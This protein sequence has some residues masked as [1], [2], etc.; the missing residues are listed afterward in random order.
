MLTNSGVTISYTTAVDATYYARFEKKFTLN[1][2]KIDG[3][4]STSENKVPL[5]GAEFTLYQG[6]D[7]GDKTV[8]YQGKS[9]K[10]TEIDSCI[11]VL[12]EDGKTATA[13][14]DGMLIPNTDYFLIE[15]RAPAGYRLLSEAKKITI[16][17]SGNNA[18]IDGTSKEITEKKVNVEL[19]NYLTLHI[20]TSGLNITGG[21][22][23]AV[24]L[25][26]LAAAAIGLFGFKISRIRSKN[27]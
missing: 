7:G 4:Q 17:D 2:S 18:L 3:D 21:W 11:T 19:A 12:S 24:G 22:Y 6:N 8:V 9:I 23:A 5:A 13:V 20:P 15:K 27:Q 1:V 14:F 26:L 16:D 25:T 10:C